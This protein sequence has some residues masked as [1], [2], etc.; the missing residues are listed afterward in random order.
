MKNLKYSI[1]F[2]VIFLY[3][4]GVIQP[5]HGGQA[6]IETVQMSIE[7]VDKEM[8]L[9]D[10]II[11]QANIIVDGVDQKSRAQAKRELISLMKRKDLDAKIKDAINDDI[12]IIKKPKTKRALHAAR[13]RLLNT[14][15]KINSQA[16]V[17]DTLAEATAMVKNA[18][19]ENLE[20]TVAQAKEKVEKAEKEQQSTMGQWY[21][22]AKRVVT[23]PV[24]Y[25][26]GEES[27]YAKT[28]FYAAVG[29]AVLA[30]GAYGM[31]Q[32]GFRDESDL[33]PGL[34]F[35]IRRDNRENIENAFINNY[36]NLSMMQEELNEISDQEKQ[37]YLKMMAPHFEQKE[38]DI[39]A[40]EKVLLDF[41]PQEYIEEIKNKVKRGE[42]LTVPGIMRDSDRV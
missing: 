22:K 9:L 24:D 1:S 15:T 30:A 26:F 7:K 16:N 39:A 31:Y 4:V 18:S 25:V 14:Y 12:E 17:V 3:V 34:S 32:Y 11:E 2:F 21:A 13:I 8:S 20:E 5:L 19:P 23:A 29:L 36:M 37:E 28:A 10:Q 33:V 27:S 35:M 41:V 40:L 42:Y 38:K 6:V